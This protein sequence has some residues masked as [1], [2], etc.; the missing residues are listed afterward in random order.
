MPPV[1]IE[2]VQALLWLVAG[3]IAF[4]FSID[5]ARIWTSISLGFFLVFVSQAYVLA[6]WVRHPVLEAIHVIIGTIAIMV[7]THGFQEYHVFSR[8]LEVSGSKAAVYALTAAVILGSL[9]FLLINPTPDPA[10]IRNMRMI[11]N[12]CWAF[13]ALINVDMI[14]KIYVQVQDSPVG[15]PFLAFILVFGLIFL[16]KGSELYLQVYNWDGAMAG[17]A[18]P[19]ARVAFSRGVH[20]VTALLSSLSVGGT[21]VYLWRTLR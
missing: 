21:F 7:I 15:K 19:T 12:T 13:L 4:Y 17:M 10:V 6:P 1:S 2:L 18:Q 3:L 9:V 8:T 20:E 14:R 5:S 11:E 16:W